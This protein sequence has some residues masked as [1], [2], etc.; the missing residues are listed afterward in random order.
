MTCS[1]CSPTFHALKKLQEYKLFSRARRHEAPQV[2]SER[3][4]FIELISQGEKDLEGYE[5]TIARLQEMIV[6][7][8]NEQR[9]LNRQ[10]GLAK[11]LMAPI[12]KLPA[13]VLR[14]I[15]IAHGSINTIRPDK[16]AT[17]DIPGFKVASICSHWRSIAIETTALWNNITVQIRKDTK[18]DSCLPLTERLLELS[19]DSLLNIYISVR[20]TTKTVTSTIPMFALLCAHANRWQCLEGS[21]DAPRPIADALASMRGRLD[22]LHTFRLL[23]AFEECSRWMEGATK[24]HT[25]SVFHLDDRSTTIP[26]SQ[27][28]DLRAKEA[29][30]PRLAGSLQKL[31]NLSSLS[32]DYL[33][34]PEADDEKVISHSNL[35][36][37][38]IF[39]A[40]NEDEEEMQSL[41]ESLTLPQLRSLCI[42]VE[43]QYLT[44]QNSLTWMSTELPSLIS[45]S[46]ALITY[47]SLKNVWMGTS[48]LISLLRIMPVLTSL[49]LLESDYEGP[50][51]SPMINDQLLS[52]MYIL[53]QDQQPILTRL[54]FLYL[55]VS[56]RASFSIPM[57][58]EMIHSR[59][60]PAYLDDD[61]VAC[62]ETVRLHVWDVAIPPNAIYPLTLL[63]KRGLDLLIKDMNGML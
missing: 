39:L 49:F 57:F 9:S 43:N 55:K 30:V 1:D 56:P 36:A 26:W 45:R 47:L 42:E 15:F 29:C 7:L 3:V 27:I 34:R 20:L 25:L 50:N 58:V 10:L 33:R 35:K 38:E 13:E 4:E 41:F 28:V 11:H 59:W 24:L 63:R 51:M 37:L 21:Y 46:S 61:E 54:T 23:G 8:K 62:I 17:C 52:R 31:T 5:E 14:Q 18:Y 40:I 19:Q 12:Q 2:A 16:S 60:K 32:V 44:S 22:N 6:T 48:D 53:H